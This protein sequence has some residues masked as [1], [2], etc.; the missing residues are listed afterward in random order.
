MTK[1]ETRYK[2]FGNIGYRSMT[3]QYIGNVPKKS[4]I[5]QSLMYNIFRKW[6]QPCF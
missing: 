3:G 2:N 5:G 1:H 6:I 4:H